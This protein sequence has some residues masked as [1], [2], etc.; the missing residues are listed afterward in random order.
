[1]SGSGIGRLELRV[2]RP[3]GEKVVDQRD[4]PKS[5]TSVPALL[6]EDAIV[7][8]NGLGDVG[9]ERVADATEPALVARGVHKREVGE[10]GIN[11]DTDDLRGVG[12][13]GQFPPP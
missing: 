8:G 4:T 7:L 2:D 10:L 11:A 1:M 5:N 9:D 12:R 3:A 6:D 13:V